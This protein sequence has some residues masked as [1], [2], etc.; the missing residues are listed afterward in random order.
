[1]SYDLTQPIAEAFV[2][3]LNTDLPAILTARRAT[4][5]GPDAAMLV[6]PAQVLDH[7]PPV[8]E[9]V[10]GCPCIGFADLDTDLQLAPGWADG[11]HQIGLVIYLTNHDPG[12]LARALRRYTGC[13]VQAAVRDRALTDADD[14][15][16]RVLKAKI[17]WGDTLQDE[18]DPRM[19][20]SWTVVVLDIGHDEE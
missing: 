17:R 4:L 8:G 14:R 1:M 9:L 20:L 6:N 15:A 10:A 16:V 5:S 18:Q 12:V 2:A 19:I 13:V 7:L 11:Q 3:R